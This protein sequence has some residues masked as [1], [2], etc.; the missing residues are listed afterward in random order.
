MQLFACDQH[1]VTLPPGHRFP[2]GKYGRLRREL[3]ARGLV[4]AA[5]LHDADPISRRDLERVH[6]PGYVGAVL[7][8]TVDPRMQRAIGLPWSPALVARSLAS[9]GGTLAA[10]R[11]ALQDGI[12]GNLAGGTH[13][14]FRDRGAGFCVWNDLAVAAATLLDSGASS[15]VSASAVRRVLIIDVDVH[16]GDGTAAIFADDPRVFTLSLHGARN[17]PFRK[18]HSTLDVELPD[19]TGDDAYLAALAPAL[20]Q[21][22]ACHPDLVFVQ[23][24]VDPL[25]GD[26]LGRLAL[27]HAGLRARDRSILGLTHRL[28]LPTVLTLGGGYAEPLDDT[29]LA[30]LGTYEEARAIHG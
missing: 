11:A 7:A 10:A 14:A 13:H 23:A 21:G 30:H 15:G 27:T 4:A 19:G 5:D 16:Q 17:F 8:G 29:V 26:K 1:E 12:A 2:M 28:G 22:L 20:E 3:L 24:G 6:D 18:Q 9:V 25:R